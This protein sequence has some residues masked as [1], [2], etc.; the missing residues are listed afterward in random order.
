MT[1]DIF[2]PNAVLTLSNHGGI[3]LQIH[4]TGWY[5]RFRY[6]GKV[7]HKWQ[8]ISETTKGRQY[9]TIK[10]RRYHLDKFERLNSI[11]KL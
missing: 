1:T 2:T 3:E 10:G 4:Q 5:A 7:S 11:N 8:K 6:Y 9:L